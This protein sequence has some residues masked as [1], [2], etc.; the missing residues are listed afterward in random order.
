M[1]LYAV[2]KYHHNKKMG[3]P[4]YFL[5]EDEMK[6]YIELSIKM[7]QDVYRGIVLDPLVNDFKTQ[8]YDLSKI[9]TFSEFQP[10]IKSEYQFL[11][12]DLYNKMI[13]DRK[14]SKRVIGMIITLIFISAIVIIGT[15]VLN[16]LPNS[17]VIY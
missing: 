1:L 9:K 8:R 14:Q 17:Q 6:A 15:I 11:A 10:L 4:K 13:E 2:E 7:E 12:K 5:T 16:H 3:Q